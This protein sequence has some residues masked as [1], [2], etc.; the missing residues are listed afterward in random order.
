MQQL[1]K[2]ISKVVA[3]YESFA[4]HRV[5]S[6]IYNFCT[7]EMSSIYMDVLKDRLYCDATD[8]QS[9]RS[10]QT[11]MYRILDCL[12]RLLAPVLAHTTEEAWAA[13][14]YKS[15]DVETVHLAAMPKVDDSVDWQGEEAKW[16]K[17]MG[18]RDEVLRELEGLRQAQKIASNQEASVSIVSDDEELVSL[19]NDFGAEAF[20]ALCI[21]SEVQIQA[22]SALKV[23]ADKS[24]HA[25]CQRCWNYW[26]SVGADSKYGDLCQR[27][28]EVVSS[29]KPV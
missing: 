20:A 15:E 1:Q 16:E 14:K 11:V 3:A 24:S 4:F 19:I 28:I 22:G 6:L 17:I 8:S 18:L 25:K 23:V 10:A 9:R 7:V 26:P 12:I 29:K 13:M 5:F 2:L 27:C 21:V